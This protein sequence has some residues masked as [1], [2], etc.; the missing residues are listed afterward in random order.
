[1]KPNKS[2]VVDS[3]GKASIH[4]VPYPTLP[5]DDYL[6]VKPRAVAINP[7]D[8]KQIDADGDRRTD[9]CQVGFDYAGTVEEV[10]PGVTLPF[11]KGDRVAG[12]IHG[13]NT[14]LKSNGGFATYATAREF[15]Q[16][17]IPESLSFEEAA[18]QGVALATI[19]LTYRFLQ[20]P[21][22]T[23]PAR[24][25]FD[26]FIYGGST[27]MGIT[28][29]QMA[30]LSGGT[31]IATSSPSNA[32]YMKSLG[33]SHVLDYKSDSLTEDILKLTGSQLKYAVDCHSDEFSATLCAKVLQGSEARMASLR[34]TED[35]VKATNPNLEH[36]EIKGY[37]AFGG[38]WN[39]AGDFEAR[40]QDYDYMKTFGP[41]FWGLLG[42]GK[43]KP[44][45]LY[46][47]HGGSGLDG[48]LAGLDKLRNGQ[49]SAGKLVYSM[50]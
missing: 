48:V 7:V 33:A 19:G 20:L 42:A 44:P 23:E 18:T 2:I 15:L 40:P 30:S 49:V 5:A 21:W 32:E 14:H 11:K 35:I 34:R 36:E 12:A 39:S 28:M 13:T 10:G 38:V 41:M 17:H 27:A 3:P 16:A 43:L 9:G 45:R 47:N 22:P 31:V 8:W 4:E 29:I 26:I 46:V 1:M 50:E 25:P 24:E 6:I 37:L